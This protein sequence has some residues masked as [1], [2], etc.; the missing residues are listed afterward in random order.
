MRTLI[1]GAAGFLGRNALLRLPHMG[2]VAALYRPDDGALEAFLRR[3]ELNA[4]RAYPC[5]LTDENGVREAAHAIGAEWD[6]CL[7]LAANTSIP[8][9]IQRPDVDLAANTLT[10][11]RLLMNMRIGH[12]VFLSSG[13]VYSGRDGLVGPETPLAPDLPYAISKLA[14]ERYIHATHAHQGNPTRAT[15][16]RFFGAYGPYE[17]ARKLYTR[18]TRRFAFERN[19]EYVVTGD[20][21]NFIDAMYVE[22]AIRALGATLDQPATGVE[23]V[24]LGVGA[25]ETVN[26]VVQQAAHVFE[27]EA[28]IIHHGESPEYISFHIDPERFATRYGVRPEVTLEDGL[29]A[30]A[31]HLAEEDADARA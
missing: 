16:I 5:D 12:L 11:L 24:D 13:A 4:V 21:N 27:L 20:G 2:E 1:V 18:L 23:T 19:P 28:R 26:S 3:H 10:L 8:Y 29:K 6:Q 15:I 7:F 30:L 14:A 22:D 25:G 31:R 9:S 17:P